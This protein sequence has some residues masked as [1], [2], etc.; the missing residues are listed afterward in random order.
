MF[1]TFPHHLENDKAVFHIPTTPTTT[2]THFKTREGKRANRPR[3]GEALAII[4]KTS[5][6]MES[7]E[8]NAG[9]TDRAS[10]H[11]IFTRFLS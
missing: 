4:R 6:R 11:L 9:L 2:Y 5:N 3:Y 8:V 7:Y 10:F 1:P